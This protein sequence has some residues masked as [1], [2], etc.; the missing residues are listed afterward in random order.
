MGQNGSKMKFLCPESNVNT[1]TSKPLA[2]SLS[3]PQSQ[4]SMKGQTSKA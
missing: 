1:V 4:T 3:E 2:I